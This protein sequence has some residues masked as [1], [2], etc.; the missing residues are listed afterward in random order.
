LAP[1]IWN[2]VPEMR[3][4]ERQVV[5]A[6]DVLGHVLEDDGQRDGGHDPAEFGLDLDGR[7]HADPF[8]EHALQAPNT[9]TMGIISQ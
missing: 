1:K 9:I 8:D 5:L 2:G 6:P 7:P 3:R 4:R